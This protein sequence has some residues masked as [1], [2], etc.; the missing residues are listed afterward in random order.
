MLWLMPALMSLLSALVFE[1]ARC[2]KICSPKGK[3][4]KKYNKANEYIT[5]P[6][7][8]HHSIINISACIG[9]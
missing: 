9:L 6:C 5:N 7:H 3:Y 4:T 2:F 1:I 8:A